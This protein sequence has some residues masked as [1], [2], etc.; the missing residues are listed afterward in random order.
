MPP[1]P[2]IGLSEQRYLNMTAG[3]RRFDAFLAD[4]L[5]FGLAALEADPR[6]ALE[7]VAARL[8]DDQLPNAAVA[9]RSWIPRI[10][11]DADWVARTGRDIGYW[12]LLN[13]MWLQPERLDADAFAGL[14]FA[15]G[16]RL[17][18]AKLP[19][20]GREARAHWTC[21]GIEE[22]N[23]EALYYRRTF[24][25]GTAP[26]Q[27]LTQSSYNYGGPLPTTQLTIGSH[28]DIAML[29]YPG[30][31][32]TRGVL[33]EGAPLTDMLYEHE[34][35]Q[36]HHFFSWA[37]QAHEQRRLLRAQPWRRSFPVAVGPLRA[38]VSRDGQG[39]YRL[40][41]RDSEDAYHALPLR[42]AAEGDD[43][44]IETHARLLALVGAA[45]FVLYGGQYDGRLRVR[46]LSL[47]R[48]V[49]PV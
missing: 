34:R 27:H 39:A 8:T 24:W 1:L 36:P 31:L 21:V 48:M 9:L 16:Y 33:P 44:G 13:R 2:T 35:Q 43:P 40:L 22:G 19:G 3:V 38:E 17:T 37:A 11:R 25:R 14:A 32:P 5:T 26:E 4:Q 47:D 23:D 10:G 42:G 46:S 41:L 45:P 12:H 49:R 7:P 29:A 6:A 20:L 28:G 15:Y 18:K 30:A